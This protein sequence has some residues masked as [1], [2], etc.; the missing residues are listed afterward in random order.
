MPLW[1]S[2]FDIFWG[3]SDILLV[4]ATK[5]FDSLVSHTSHSHGE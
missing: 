1:A 2:C 4:R 5:G 3:R